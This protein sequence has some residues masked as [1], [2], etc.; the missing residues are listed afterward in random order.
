MTTWEDKYIIFLSAYDIKGEENTSS[1]FE[2]K[3]QE[4]DGY[5]CMYEFGKHLLHSMYE[6]ACVAQEKAI[7]MLL[8]TTHKTV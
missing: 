3:E 1:T 8:F 2:K 4:R 7:S 5:V 6:C